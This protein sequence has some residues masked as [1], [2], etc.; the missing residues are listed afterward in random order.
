MGLFDAVS[1]LFGMDNPADSAM[2]YYN[3]INDVLKKY[4]SPYMEAGQRALNPLEREYGKLTSDPSGRLN[5]IG[6]GYQQSPGFKFALQQALQGANSASAAGGMLGSPQS[7]QQNMG[8]A[9]NLAN[10]D[11][12][13]WLDH[14]LGLY[15]AGLSG[16]HNIYNTGAEAGMNLGG[17]LANSLASQG[18]LA[19]QGAANRNQGIMDLL[20]GGTNLGAMYYFGGKNNISPFS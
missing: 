3:Q 4:Y 18:S 11:Y 20:R 17:N 2:P 7:Q 5:A 8:I 10:Q 13:Q 16:E 15:G 9:T 19:F 12:N 6:A 14:A 1:G